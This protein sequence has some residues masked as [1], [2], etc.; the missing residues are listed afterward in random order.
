[1]ASV[2]ISCAHCGQAFEVGE[3]QGEVR[4]PECG[5][6]PGEARAASALVAPAVAAP[7]GDGAAAAAREARPVPPVVSSGREPPPAVDS[8]RKPAAGGEVLRDGAA[9]GGSQI[10]AAASQVLQYGREVTLTWW[11]RAR[12]SFAKHAR[13]V[14]PT[15]EEQDALTRS[16]VHSPAVQKHFVWRRSLLWFL[17]VP[18]TFTAIMQSINSLADGFDW[19]TAFGVVLI[20]LYVASV[21]AVPVTAFLAARAWHRPRQSRSFLLVGFVASFLVN[22]LFGFVPVYWI[23]KLDGLPP[24]VSAVGR[25]VIQAFWALLVFFTLLPV[26]L[27]LLPGA[28]RACVRIK[29]L[30]PE[31]IVPGWLLITL[32]PVYALL[33]LTLFILVNQ[34]SGNLL[35]IAGAALIVAAP[36]A[37]LVKTGLFIRPLWTQ[38][39]WG[40]VERTQWAY[41]AILA[42]GFG[43]LVLYAMTGRV[44]G[45]PI[46]AFRRADAIIG[47]WS[48]AWHAFKFGLDYLGRSLFIT[49]LAMDYFLLINV[50]VWRNT[51][52][53]EKTEAAGKYE[54]TVEELGKVLGSE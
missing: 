24:E 20:L 30:F 12:K 10:G 7:A 41:Q 28:I 26:I 18:A 52:E 32:A 6:T 15:A 50:S 17:L 25:E 4:C 45:H 13:D 43:F 53:F 54:A 34:M 37:Y 47:F 21:W 40:A 5:K 48:F 49:A 31:S 33:L 46:V 2:R 36:V 8:V 16:G 22:L 27:S 42:L 51:R 44:L 29:V 19:A 9:E 14:I 38:E 39:G 23:V 1:M 35:L 3:G 11:G